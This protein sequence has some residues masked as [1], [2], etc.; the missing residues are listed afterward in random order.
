MQDDVDRDNIFKLFWKMNV[1]AL[2]CFGL[3]DKHALELPRGK[4]GFSNEM[5]LN[6]GHN[7]RHKVEWEKV[8]A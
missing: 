8:H 3:L 2:M 1:V 4:L 5:T 6:K 7:Q